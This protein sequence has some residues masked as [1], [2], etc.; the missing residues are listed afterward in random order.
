MI[1]AKHLLLAAAVASGAL[2]SLLLGC[3]GQ[4]RRAA[5]AGPA[6]PAF[7]MVALGTAGGLEEDN[8]TSFLLGPTD[9]ASFVALDAGTLHAGIERAVQRGAFEGI[10]PPPDSPLTLGGHILLDRVRAVLVSHAH[11]DHWAGLVVSSPDDAP[12]T[13]LALASTHRAMQEHVWESPLWA[14]FSDRGAGALKKYAL[15][16]LAPDETVPIPGTAMT[17]RAFPLSHGTLESTAFLVGLGGKYALYLGDTGPDRVE[18]QGRLRALWQ[19]VAP[20]ARDGRLRALFIECS[21]PDPRDDKLLFGHL[22]PSH[23]I[24][25]LG[26]LAALV[27]EARPEQALRDLTVIVTHIKPSLR[28]GPTPRALVEAQLEPLRR[29]VRLLLPEAGLR[30]D[31]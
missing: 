25:E 10:V 1:R 9:G 15:R 24:E 7:A 13:I 29:R 17:V 2:C 14:N 11:L 19:A 20:L 28:R 16:T 26:A 21:F 8:L 12:K 4:P 30:Y 23:L 31:L 3:A 5:E 18:K 27:D 22:T 6:S